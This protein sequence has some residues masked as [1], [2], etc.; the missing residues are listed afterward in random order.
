MTPRAAAA[1][2]V[3]GLVLGTAVASGQSPSARAAA[4]VTPRALPAPAPPAPRGGSTTVMGFAWTATNQ[5]LPNATVQLRN[6]ETGRVEARTVTNAA[7]EFVFR[8][9]EGNATYVVEL[10]D[11]RGR[12]VAVGQAFVIAAGETVATFVRLGA[13]APWYAGLFEHT[14]AAVVATAASLG[15]TAVAPPGQPASAR[16]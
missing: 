6:V 2:L 4:T 1:L 13:V 12:V 10:V 16:R 14:A 15:V 8:E 9:V 5:P 7:G 3:A 11:E